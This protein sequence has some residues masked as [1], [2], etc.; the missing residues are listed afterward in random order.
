MEIDAEGKGKLEKSTIKRNSKKDNFSPYDKVDLFKNNSKSNQNLVHIKDN[1]LHSLVPEKESKNELNKE[2]N[3]SEN[4]QIFDYSKKSSEILSKKFRSFNKI[5]LDNDSTEIIKTKI[6]RNV[7]KKINN[8]S[9]TFE[10]KNNLLIKLFN[11]FVHKVSE[12]HQTFGF[13]NNN[14]N[15][16]V[17]GK[18]K[19][20]SIKFINFN[21]IFIFERKIIEFVEKRI[22]FYNKIINTINSV[23]SKDNNINLDILNIF[24]K[25]IDNGISD[26]NIVQKNKI[27]EKDYSPSDL[28]EEQVI[29]SYNHKNNIATLNKINDKNILSYI[30]NLNTKLKILNTDR[31][32][33]NNNNSYK[34]IILPSLKTSDNQLYSNSFRNPVK[35]QNSIS[36][37]KSNKRYDIFST[38]NNKEIS[39]IKKDHDGIKIYLKEMNSN[40]SKSI[41]NK[42]KD[43]DKDNTNNNLSSKDKEVKIEHN[44]ELNNDNLRR[45]KSVVALTVPDY[46]NINNV[47]DYILNYKFKEE[48]KDEKEE[49]EKIERKKEKEKEKEK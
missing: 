31:N 3:I 35:C 34:K 13:F 47:N 46:H 27:K 37:H 21:E 33:P 11:N 18:I 28:K 45:R 44:S 32:E 30:N 25:E 26:I 6:F 38:Q 10:D 1:N 19:R 40:I 29:D 5:N 49:K 12:A 16:D 24:Y 41:D 36:T 15:V 2:K 17:N 7:G 42:N 39:P 48:P 20:M 22:F 4:T 43:K 14:K 23:F 8:F 9:Q